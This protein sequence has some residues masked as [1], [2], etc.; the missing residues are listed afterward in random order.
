MAQEL[1]AR[2]VLALDQAE[3]KL[4]RQLPEYI[5]VVVAFRNIRDQRLYRQ[6]FPSWDEYCRARF[7]VS[8]ENVDFHIA[9][10]EGAGKEG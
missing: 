5:K 4:Q 8:A 6:A 2:E 10:L 3:A 7:G 9:L 1:S